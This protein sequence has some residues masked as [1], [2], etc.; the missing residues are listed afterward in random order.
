MIIL[1]VFFSSCTTMS[2]FLLFSE[3]SG[4]LFNSFN[5]ND[6]GGPP[7]DPNKEREKSL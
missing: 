2:I 3:I 4:T 1:N 5:G 7:R 6:Y